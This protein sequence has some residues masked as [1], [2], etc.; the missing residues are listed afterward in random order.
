MTEEYER[1][2]KIMTHRLSNPNS[3][4][5]EKIVEGIEIM[6]DLRVS[7]ILTELSERIKK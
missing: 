4:N 6:I 2:K 3:S 7:E 5:A 1:H